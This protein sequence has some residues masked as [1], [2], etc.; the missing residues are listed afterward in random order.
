MRRFWLLLFVLL[1]IF[2]DSALA[3][4]TVYAD[5]GGVAVFMEDGKVGLVDTAGNVL[6]PAEYDEISPFGDADCALIKRNGKAGVI[7]CDGTV[8][9][10]CDW[11]D[12]FSCL[13]PGTRFA[14]MCRD[15]ND[16]CL[17]DL[18]TGETVLEGEYIFGL[19]D[20][21]ITALSYGYYDYW[22]LEPPFTTR[23]FDMNLQP[24]ITLEGDLE[25]KTAAGW[26]TADG[27]YWDFRTY[28]LLDV[29]GRPVVGGLTDFE[30]N[31]DSAIYYSR[32]VKNPIGQTLDK[33]GKHQ[34]NV[35]NLLHN[36]F[37]IDLDTAETIA[38]VCMNDWHF[39][40]VW[41]PDGSRIEC[42]GEDVHAAMTAGDSFPVKRDGRWGYVDSKGEMIIPAVYDEAGPFIDG[43][44]VVIED[45]SY[46]LIDAKGQTLPLKWK[47]EL[48]LPNW[49]NGPACSRMRVV[50]G[51]VDG[52][53]RLID[54]QGSFVT[55]EIFDAESFRPVGTSI[56]GP[57]SIYN[58]AIYLL[59]DARGRLSAFDSDGIELC[60]FEADDW[61]SGIIVE[62]GAALWAA[63]DD[64]W[65]L[66][67]L[68]GD[69]AGEWRIA[70]KYDFVY[71][72]GE[73]TFYVTLSNRAFVVDT[74]GN[75]LIPIAQDDILD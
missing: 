10:A 63:I 8:V 27:S 37:D 14:R 73:G 51:V 7:R 11:D 31:R 2:A 46:H 45:G 20:G 30:I 57:W 49:E 50:A 3:E 61:Q 52:E 71:R 28:T 38:R 9:L 32:T 16:Q 23:L 40:G 66:M 34:K 44:A 21:Y 64:K 70:P 56:L 22:E 18:H 29:T 58:D 41:R 47:G 26:I 53:V 13:L 54:R 12:N 67:E 62:D 68:T 24:V 55:D 39:S 48:Y 43:S 36:M 59:K 69:R 6:C 5:Q 25:Q 72:Y 42:P 15:L 60:R 4:R 19:Q 74:Q 75:V 65:G 33:L 35:K 1:F 17:I